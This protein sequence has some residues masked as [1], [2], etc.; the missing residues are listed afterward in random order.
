[1]GSRFQLDRGLGA[2]ISDEEIRPHY[3]RHDAMIE[4]LLALRC[5]TPADF[6][7]KLVGATKDGVLD[8]GDTA[9]GLALMAEA[10]ALIGGAQ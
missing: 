7:A 10:R 5:E 4:R 2:A 3:R 6:A 1:M 8:L 9:A